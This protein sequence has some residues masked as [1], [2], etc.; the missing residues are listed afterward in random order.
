MDSLN[1]RR[2]THTTRV[3][4]HIDEIAK[5]IQTLIDKGF[6]YYAK[7]GSIYFDIEEYKLKTN[8][9]YPALRPQHQAD[10]II[11][12]NVD[13]NEG[14]K[15]SEDFALWK[16][17]HEFGY[18]TDQL[19]SI[20]RPGWHIECS[21]MADSICGN[22]LHIHSGGIDLEF[23][24][25][26]NEIAQSHAYH[27]PNLPPHSIESPST[28]RAADEDNRWVEL[29]VHVGHLNIA[30]QKMSKSL[31]NF[32][33]IEE[34]LSNYSSNTVRMMILQQGLNDPMDLSDDLFITAE[35]SL[36]M[37]KNF[38]INSLAL[39]EINN[40]K[41]DPKPNSESR[42]LAQ[43][44]YETKGAVHDALSNNF[45]TSLAIK[46]LRSLVKK[47][48]TYVK[49]VNDAHYHLSI[50][51]SINEYIG[52]ILHIFGLSPFQPDSQ[53]NSE[54]CSPSA[55]MNVFKNYRN[56]IRKLASSSKHYEILQQCDRVRD[57]ELRKAGVH[58]E[59][60][61]NYESIW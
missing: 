50:I 60:R 14:K 10:E 8:Y 33:T 22:H 58:L 38:F 36:N 47:T 2:P 15:R 54:K 11:V 57:K 56:K 6:A 40:Y 61:E 20:G 37:F 13:S 48:N 9:N 41:P 43:S 7:D 27:Y 30:G 34:V 45:N 55:I 17:D 32:T 5:Y 24:H 4:E 28:D 42:A 29:F 25:H 12:Q 26:E 39:K 35:E 23:P 53:K 16:V 21:A 52:R 19:E 59:D 51:L 44:L 46:E 49:G 18:K 1:V 31:K 3:S